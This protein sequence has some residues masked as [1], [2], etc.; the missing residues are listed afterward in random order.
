VTKNNPDNPNKH[1]DEPV[2][3]TTPPAPAPTPAPVPDVATDPPQPPPSAAEIALADAQAAIA[4]RPP[5]QRIPDDSSPISLLR[6]GDVPLHTDAE[7]LTASPLEEWF[8]GVEWRTLVSWLGGTCYQSTDGSLTLI[9]ES[10]DHTAAGAVR[11]TH[12]GPWEGG[13]IGYWGPVVTSAAEVGALL[14]EDS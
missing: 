3:D 5:R 13:V 4:Q 1:K 8:P 2:T 11:Y 7:R 6:E 14:L 12:P 10:G 9:V